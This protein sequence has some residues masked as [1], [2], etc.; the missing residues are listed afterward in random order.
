[1]NLAVVSCE[2]FKREFENLSEELPHRYRF[3]W[4]PFALHNTPEKMATALQEILDGI[5]DADAI[6][7]GYGLCSRGI[8][9]VTA[10]H[11]PIVVPRA[12]DCMTLFLGSRERYGREFSANPGTYYYSPGWVDRYDPNASQSHFVPN[13]EAREAARA[14]QYARYVELYGEDNA[15]YLLDLETQ[16]QSHYSRT[17]FIDTGYGNKDYYRAF[18][19]HLAAANGWAYDEVPGDTGLMRRFLNAEWNDDFLIV[20][21]GETIRDVVNDDIITVERLQH[22]DSESKA[23]AK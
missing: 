11:A 22:P 9:G 5:A 17:A 14:Q 4:V 18:V 13:T 10:R 2:V 1:M 21:P 15:K 7:L 19:K 12:H 3:E 23:S 16:W 20:E 8:V 6:L